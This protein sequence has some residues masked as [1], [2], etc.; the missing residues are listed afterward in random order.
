MVCHVQITFLSEGGSRKIW[1]CEIKARTK[2]EWIHRVKWDYISVTITAHLY[3]AS[4]FLCPLS[5]HLS[6]FLTSSHLSC[7]HLSFCRLS[8]HHFFFSLF[9]SSRLCPLYPLLC[10]VYC[11]V[12]TLSLPPSYLLLGFIFIPSFLCSSSMSN[13][14]SL[15][16]ILSP[17]PLSDFLPTYLSFFQSASLSMGPY[18][19]YLHIAIS[20][21]EI[22]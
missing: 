2:V 4:H 9:T 16:F 18:Y 6:P 22:C 19:I 14:L 3:T 21:T 15:S 11:V 5:S 10:L 13:M 17:L 12:F 1:R 20:A 7:L 8:S